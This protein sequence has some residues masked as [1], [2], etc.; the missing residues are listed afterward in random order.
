MHTKKSPDE[1]IEPPAKGLTVLCSTAELIWNIV[2]VF[3]TNS[4]IYSYK[5]I[6]SHIQKNNLVTSYWIT[7]R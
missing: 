7:L 5:Q 4:G 1:G 6:N 3:I 2:L